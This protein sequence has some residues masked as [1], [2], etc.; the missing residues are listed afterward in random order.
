MFGKA[1][2]RSLLAAI[3]WLPMAYEGVARAQQ[4]HLGSIQQIVDFS[5][6]GGRATELRADDGVVVWYNQ[7]SS[8]QSKIEAY[9]FTEQQ[10]HTV[11]YSTSSYFAVISP[12]VSG[13]TIVWSE[14]ISVSGQP[15]SV[16]NLRSFDL[17]T[18]QVTEL[19]NSAGHKTW[20]TLEN[21]TIVWRQYPSSGTPD[22]GAYDVYMAQSPT[23]TPQVVSADPLAYEGENDI[24]QGRVLYTYSNSN[25]GQKRLR[26]LDLGSGQTVFDQNSGAVW[27]PPRTRLEGN[28]VMW[29]GANSTLHVVDILAS[30]EL[31]TIQNVWAADMS[32]SLLVYYNQQSQSIFTQDLTTGAS[33]LLLSGVDVDRNGLALDGNRLTWAEKY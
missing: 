29:G 22:T 30:Q 31:A 4:V 24:S 6:S 13:R 14:K 9:D 3:V 17:D 11:R 32:S 8:E 1:V 23:F 16:Y 15:S 33:S 28:L 27:T 19:T 25:T 21:G 7:I 26:V 20:P 12:D 5:G 18:N 2:V 10:F